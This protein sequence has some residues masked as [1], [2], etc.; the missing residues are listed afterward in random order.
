MP[1]YYFITWKRMRFT[2][3][4]VNDGSVLVRLEANLNSPLENSGYVSHPMASTVLLR[5]TRANPL[6]CQ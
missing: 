2:E 1:R 6:N 5:K 4:V 3:S